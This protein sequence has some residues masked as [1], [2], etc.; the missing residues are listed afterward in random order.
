MF[1]LTTW[2]GKM[3]GGRMWCIFRGVRDRASAGNR[4]GS[5]WKVKNNQGLVLVGYDTLKDITEQTHEVLGSNL[6]HEDVQQLFGLYRYFV[7]S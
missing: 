6:T 2:M 4:A 7:K 5:V 1:F 3:M